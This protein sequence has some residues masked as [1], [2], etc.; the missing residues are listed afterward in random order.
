MITYPVDIIILASYFALIFGLLAC[1]IPSIARARNAPSQT[2]L[3]FLIFAALSLLTTWIYMFKYFHHSYSQWLS[4]ANVVPESLLD[5]ISHW[6]HNVSLF[7]DAWRTV[8]VGAIQWLWSHQLCAFTVSVWTPFIALE[9]IN[10]NICKNPYAIGMLTYG[11][12]LNL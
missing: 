3:L 6:L 5:S 12:F 2:P 10:S 8:S 7:D 4:T 9:G 11:R 1:I